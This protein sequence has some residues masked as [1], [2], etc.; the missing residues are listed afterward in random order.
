MFASHEGI[1]LPRLPLQ[2]CAPQGFQAC[3]NKQVALERNLWADDKSVAAWGIEWRLPGDSWNYPL[4]AR[5]ESCCL[6]TSLLVSGGSWGWL[7]NDKGSF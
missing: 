6:L 5:P 3:V 1:T 2:D 4:E 7:R